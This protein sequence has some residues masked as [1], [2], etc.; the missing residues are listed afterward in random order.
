MISRLRLRFS[1]HVFVGAAPLLIMAF[2]MIVAKPL[3][4]QFSAAPIKVVLPY[5][6]GSP[7]DVAARL[8]AP[9]LATRLGQT[10][11]VE[12]R[13]GGGSTIGTNAVAKAEPDGRTLLFANSINH[14]IAPFLST[15]LSYDPIKD[16]A[17][18][19]AV[20]QTSW[21]M[22]IPSELPI[23]TLDEFIRYAKSNPNKL[24]FGFGQGTAPQ[25]VG[26]MFKR[27]TGASMANISY[28]GGAHAVTDMLAGIIH[29]NF[30]TVATLLPLINAGKLRPLAVTSAVRSPDLPSVPTMQESGF[31]ELAVGFW[32]GLLAPVKTPKAV[33]DT[34]GGHAQAILKD[35]ALIASMAKLGLE[36]KI[37]NAEEFR[38]FLVQE[39]VKWGPVAQQAG[40]K[41]N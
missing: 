37:G 22:V 12:N 19:A 16:F 27:A 3:H 13:P 41:L 15:N 39:A 5:T 36:P 20:A 28:K 25:L 6:A 9:P 1:R 14:V 7:N 35:P 34:I 29:V 33:I 32:S 40:L 24:N 26:D 10:I 31:P 4:A 17:P 21:V 23:R 38:G 2:G 30:G 18:I 8:I 11:V